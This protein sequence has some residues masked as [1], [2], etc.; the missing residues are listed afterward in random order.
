MAVHQRDPQVSCLPWRPEK[1][2]YCSNEAG[3]IIALL[4][5][6]SLHR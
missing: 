2:L 3:T 1:M 5:F 4:L 6:L